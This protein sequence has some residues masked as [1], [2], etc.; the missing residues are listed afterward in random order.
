MALTASGAFARRV[1][2]QRARRV[3]DP[4]LTGRDILRH[5]R[6]GTDAG[7]VSHLAMREDRGVDADLDVV[8]DLSMAADDST[9]GD[10]AV[11]AD[12]GVMPDVNVL[13][14][15]RPAADMGRALRAG[16]DRHECLD[17]GA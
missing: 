8:A 16:V 10:L 14:Q 6:T 4:R 2:H 15:P 3:T 11:L 12:V 5:D 1:L 7:T 9:G 17:A 13:H